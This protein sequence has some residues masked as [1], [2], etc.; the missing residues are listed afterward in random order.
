MTIA[1]LD[2]FVG[3]F[4]NQGDAESYIGGHGWTKEPGWFYYD[5][6]LSSIGVYDGT[7]WLYSN[8][9]N[10]AGSSFPYPPLD[11]DLYYHTTKKMLFGYDAGRIL[12]LSVARELIQFGR[13]TLASNVQGFLGLDRFNFN[14]NSGLMMVRDGVITSVSIRN[15][16]NITRT[17]A[18]RVNNGDV[19]DVSLAGVS[20]RVVDP[21]NHN[22]AAQDRIS[23][24]VD[25]AVAGNDLT[26]CSALIEVAWR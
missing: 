17:I 12:W 21:A 8:R 15:E 9:Q 1:K 2:H 26:R 25:S 4:T 24:F 18:V 14:P 7:R 10:F 19:I 23:V 3:S 5:T 6:T 11:G 16:G 13:A 22:F 20:Q